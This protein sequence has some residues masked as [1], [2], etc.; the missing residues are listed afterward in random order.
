MSGEDLTMDEMTKVMEGLMSGTIDP[1]LAGSF[2]TAL[3]M[4]KKQWLK[5]LLGHGC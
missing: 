3:K 4:K 1:I 2:L 5:L